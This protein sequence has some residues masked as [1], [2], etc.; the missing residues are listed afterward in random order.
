MAEVVADIENL[1]VIDTKGNE[2]ELWDH[3]YWY[4]SPNRTSYH[5][6]EGAIN[7]YSFGM[8]LHN[9][10]CGQGIHVAMENLL[11]GIEVTVQKV[12]GAGEAERLIEE[13]RLRINPQLPSRLRCFYLNHDKY[14]ALA[15]IQ[16]W[17]FTER[18]LV[19]CY[20]IRSSAFYHYADVRL[21][22]VLAKDPTQVHLAEQY[23]DTF[24]PQDPKERQFLEVLVNG[25]LY[26]PDWKQFPRIDENEL[27][28]WQEAN[29]R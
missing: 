22:E 4:L 18:E 26:F 5:P 20:S 15:R 9:A 27:I 21:F 24:N 17:G 28:K 2:Y 11:D 12:G 7:P 23:W 8:V 25:A 16:A 10:N 19:R 3:E 14:V 1:R 29:Q 13:A 6:A